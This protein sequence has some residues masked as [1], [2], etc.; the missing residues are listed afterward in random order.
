MKKS[1]YT[2]KGKKDAY[3]NILLETSLKHLM[4][5]QTD[6]MEEE[7]S[8]RSVSPHGSF[9]GLKI[10]RTLKCHPEIAGEGV[11]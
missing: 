6:F 10:E 8:F 3:G 1:H 7:T 9:L 2:L 4:S 11:E 5:L